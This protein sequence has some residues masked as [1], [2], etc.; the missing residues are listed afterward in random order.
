MDLVEN[1]EQ[2]PEQLAD[3]RVSVVDRRRTPE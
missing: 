2:I 1:V 3:A